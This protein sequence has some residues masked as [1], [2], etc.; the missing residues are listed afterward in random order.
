MTRIVVNKTI[1]HAKPHSICFLPQYQRNEIFVLTIEH[2]DSDLKVHALHY[3]NEL[4]VCVSLFQ[5]LLQTR[6]ICRNNTKKCLGKEQWRVLVIDSTYHENHILIYFLPQYQCQRKCFSSECELKR[7]L[8]AI[9]W[10]ID[11]SSVVWTLKDFCC[12]NVSM[13]CYKT[14]GKHHSVYCWVMDALGT[15]AKYSRS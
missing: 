11:A 12:S 2:T 3:A 14:N 8:R 13:L 6:L 4:L 15:F 1:Y 5:K 9:A 10:H 7:S